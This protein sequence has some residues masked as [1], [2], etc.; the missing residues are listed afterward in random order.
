MTV[1]ESETPKK[2][3]SEIRMTIEIRPTGQYIDPILPK[4]PHKL[5]EHF[6]L[7]LDQYPS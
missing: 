5:C 1:R 4:P 2:S 6:A 7:P 3:S